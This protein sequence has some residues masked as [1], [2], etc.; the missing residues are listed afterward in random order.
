[1]YSHLPQEIRDLAFCG[2]SISHRPC[3]FHKNR[4]ALGP[5][6]RGVRRDPRGPDRTVVCRAYPSMQ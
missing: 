5:R 1:M 6:P 3:A 2:R 4:V